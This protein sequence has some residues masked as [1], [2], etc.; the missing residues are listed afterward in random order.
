MIDKHERANRLAHRML[1]QCVGFDITLTVAA[2]CV[3]LSNSV[4]ETK[5]YGAD[6]KELLEELIKALRDDLEKKNNGLQS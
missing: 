5:Q 1:N 3:C 4:Y 2:C 6:P